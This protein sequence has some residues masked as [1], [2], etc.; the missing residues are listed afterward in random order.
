MT[1][2]IFDF[3]LAF[4]TLFLLSGLLIICWLIAVIDTKSNGVFVQERV[5]QFGLKFNIYKFRTIKRK[6]GTK[7]IS[8][9]GQFLRKYKLDEL[10]QLINILKGEMSFV[11]PRPDIVGYYD[12]LTGDNRKILDLRP[13]LTSIASLKYRNEEQFLSKLENPLTYNDNFIFPDKVRLNLEYFYNHTFFGDLKIMIK[14][15]IFTLM[16]NE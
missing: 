4:L 10:P 12:K 7:L 2:Q 14:T 8:N 6:A 3:V 1:K 15:V 9:R 11:G 16:K 5:G 13:G